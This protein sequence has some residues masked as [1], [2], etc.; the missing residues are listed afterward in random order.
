MHMRVHIAFDVQVIKVV[1]LGAV[2]AN[3]LGQLLWRHIGHNNWR[4]KRAPP[5]P[6]DQLQPDDGSSN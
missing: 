1:V 5:P 4:R 2:A 6:P 3:I